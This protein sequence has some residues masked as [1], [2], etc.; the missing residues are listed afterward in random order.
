MK[1]R[2]AKK[3]IELFEIDKKT[4]INNDSSTNSKSS[5]RKS[6]T[7]TSNIST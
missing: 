1:T 3:S 7:N 4:K 5:S 6:N 2:S